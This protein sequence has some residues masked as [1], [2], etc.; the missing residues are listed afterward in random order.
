VRPGRGVP[1]A[2]RPSGRH[3]ILPR[4]RS[5]LIAAVT[6][7]AVAAPAAASSQGHQRIFPGPT[8]AKAWTA[9]V[10]VQTVARARPDAGRVVG[11]ISTSAPWSGGRNELLV[12]G[13]KHDS[14]GRTWLRVE[15]PRRPNHSTG[16]MLA[17]FARVTSTPYRIVVSLSKRTLSLYRAGK[18]VKA[19]HSVVGAPGTPTPVGLYAVSTAVRQPDPGA[20]Y[21]PY[22]LLLNAFSNVYET[23]EGGPGTIG[24][25]GRAGASL[26]TPLGTA[27]S[28]GCVRID[29]DVVT[30]LARVAGPGTPVEIRA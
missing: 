21:G 19:V 24:I 11:Q 8:P 28:H 3:G 22:V 2:L 12:L 26:S 29:N 7:A 23:F 5:I 15:L 25:H 20:F 9:E 10:K 18:V 13:S 27:L 16:W 4:V 6:L 30:L 17:D 14:K 1:A